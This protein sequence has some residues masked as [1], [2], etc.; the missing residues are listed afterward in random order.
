MIHHEQNQ[1]VIQIIFLYLLHYR[2][3]EKKILLKTDQDIFVE[4]AIIK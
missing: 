4:N 1:Y 3:V 2:I